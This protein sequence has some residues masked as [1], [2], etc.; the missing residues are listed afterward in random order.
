MP[1]RIPSSRS[2]SPAREEALRA[3]A[4][5]YV[6]DAA[7]GL[8]EEDRAAIAA[9]AE[10]QK[11]VLLIANKIDTVRSG[12]GVPE[13]AVPLCGVAP[14]AAEKLQGMLALRL[15]P[16]LS[17]EASDEVLGNARQRD[18]V[19]RAGRAA[20]DAFEALRLGDSP[21]YAVTHVDAALSAL[22]DVFGQTTPEEVLRRIF[23]TFCIG[24]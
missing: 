20:A 10:D 14:E 17:L 23:A 21:E 6:L 8:C 22:A 5:L 15:F 16:G 3:D 24:K 7:V 18:L 1:R 13:G 2:V 9:L 19:L 11:P 4:V 12:L